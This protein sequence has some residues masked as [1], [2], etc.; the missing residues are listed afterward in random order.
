VTVVEKTCDTLRVDVPRDFV[1]C[2][3]SV[4]LMLMCRELTVTDVTRMVDKKSY[5][6][7]A[8]RVPVPRDFVRGE[9]SVDS[10]LICREMMCR[11]LMC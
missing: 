8:L 6:A 2:R 9:T 5:A 10:M 3:T 11:K 7:Q 1:R 4:D